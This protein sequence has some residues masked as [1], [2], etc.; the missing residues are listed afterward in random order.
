MYRNSVWTSA[1]G[2]ASAA[3]SFGGI[4]DWEF[5]AILVMKLDVSRVLLVVM[6][7]V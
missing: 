5:M 1:A 4:A 6:V 2:L 7:E 3:V